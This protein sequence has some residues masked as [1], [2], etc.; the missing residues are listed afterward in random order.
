[1]NLESLHDLFLQSSGIS[2]DTRNIESNHLFFALKGPNFNANTFA[3]RALEAGALGVV[4]DE[5]EYKIDD[6]CIL[7]NNVLEALQK[8]ANY[9][10]KK[11]KAQILSLTGSNGKTTTS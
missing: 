8:L 10:R 1:M 4:I 3:E 9:H 11:S 5:N 6:R 2:T 7:V